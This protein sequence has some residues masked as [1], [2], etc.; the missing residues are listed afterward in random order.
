MKNETPWFKQN[1]PD[2]T[3]QGMRT[4]PGWLK[5]YLDK[6]TPIRPYG[7]FP[8]TGSRMPDYH[9]TESEVLELSK[10][11]GTVKLKTVVQPIS[12]FQSKKVEKLMDDFL[13]C[14]GCHQ[15]DGKG[16]R[17]GP[18]LS[19]TG[20]RLTDD[21]IEKSVTLPHMVMPKSIMPKTAMSTNFINLI[22]SYLAQ[23]SSNGKIQYLNLVQ[24]PPY[25]IRDSYS[26]NCAPCHGLNGDGTG[27]NREYLPTEPGNFTDG[28]LMGQR[29]DDTLFDTIHI[30]G[31][32]MN[33]SHLMPGWGEK[34]S[35]KEI[36]SY[37]EKIRSFCNC[38]PPA[39]SED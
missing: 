17:V 31:R 15:M 1:A 16:G 4:Q 28:E 25:Q 36:V 22:I 39:W 27:F 14:L 7:Y 10:W 9:L 19:N 24:K 12:A 34:L 33:K 23:K 5:K 32:M 18:D 8:G 30:G 38:D 29:S 26:A 2:L 13:S 21:F 37:V 11:L 35:R 3:A 20:N 6:P